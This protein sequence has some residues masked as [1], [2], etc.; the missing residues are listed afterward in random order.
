MPYTLLRIDF[1]EDP[2]CKWCRAKGTLKTGI[3]RILID[4]HGTEVQAGPTCAKKHAINPDERVPDLTKA[5]LELEQ[6]EPDEVPNDGG[7]AGGGRSVGGTG[8]ARTEQQEKLRRDRAVCYLL[9]RA[10]K[11][12]GFKNVSTDSLSEA[13]VRYL[14][15]QLSPA[16][17]DMLE[18]MMTST[19]TKWPE[20][21]LKNLQAVYACHYWIERFLEQ[22][23]KPFIL[24][25]HSFLKTHLRLSALQV[26]RLNECLREQGRPLSI[27][28]DAF[29]K[30][31]KRPVQP[32][33]G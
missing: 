25:L 10:E 33:Q 27:D 28:P 18:K 3:V 11:L 12:V 5:T 4:E 22:E 9:L 21:S 2:N 20:M 1:S 29:V 8:Q 13:Y 31:V 24:D 19:R 32:T 14:A 7:N 30:K 15:D 23:S 26:E 17:I 6:N 16:D